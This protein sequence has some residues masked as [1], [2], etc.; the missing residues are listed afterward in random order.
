MAS[1]AQQRANNKWL[2]ENYDQ[3]AIRVPKGTKDAWKEHA[4]AQ[5]LSL[6]QFIQE[7]V[8]E[9]VAKGGAS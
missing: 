9:K 1:E 8:D 6:A 2:R 5:G 4:E 7:A 3:V